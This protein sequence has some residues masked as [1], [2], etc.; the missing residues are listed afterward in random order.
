MTTDYKTLLNAAQYDAVVYND[1]P[2]LIVAG[3]GSGKTRVLTYKI[4]YLIE[5]GYPAA[6]ILA[7]TFTNK[8]ARE[9]KSRIAKVVGDS[10][11]RWLWM[12]TFHSIFARI[13]RQE[14]NK[15]S[16]SRDFT[17]YDAA[18]SKG[19][20]RD[21]IKELELDEKKY[22]PKMVVGRISMAKN[23]LVT[24]ETYASSRDWRE[25]DEMHGCP[26][27]HEVYSKYSERC[28]IANAMDFDDLLL[29]V[30]ELF[31]KHPDVL[32]HYQ[33]KF[34]YILVD[35]YQDTNY[36][37]H[38]IVSLLSALHN[39][40]CV[41]GDDAQSI[42]S[43][44][45][46]NIGNMLHFQSSF[47]G[48]RV[49]KLEQNYR[50]TQTIVNAANAL[51]E[52]N[53]NQIRK[54]VFSEL[55]VGQKIV[56]SRSISDLDEGD[57][58]AKKIERLVR[59]ERRKPWNEGGVEHPYS[60]IA[61]LYRTNAQSRA[62]EKTFVREGIPYKIFGGLS[63]YQRK[64]IK[65]VL[66]YMRLVINGDDEE[67][68][69]RIINYPARKI[70][71]VTQK[72][73]LDAAHQYNTSPL[74]I[75]QDI[76]GYHVD[77][78]GTTAKV[79][80]QFGAMIADFAE[81][82][83][84]TD[85]YALAEDIIHRSGIA[86]DILGDDDPDN[87]ERRQNIQELL[88]AI[89]EF[90]VERV[91]MG[92][93]EISLRDFL[94]EVALLTDQDEKE[95]DDVDRV[96]LMTIHS[97]KG[98]EFNHVFIV[99]V[100]EGLMPM[101]EDSNDQELEEER[102]LCYVAITRAKETCNISYAQSRFRNGVTDT[103]MPSRF[104]AEIGPE[105]LDL[106]DTYVPSFMAHPTYTPFTTSPRTAARPVTTAVRNRFSVNAP[107]QPSAAVSNL[108]AAR[109]DQIVVGAKVKHATFG[110][111]QVVTIEGNDVGSRKAKI[112]FETSGERVLLLKYAKL[113][114]IQ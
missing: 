107:Q 82:K 59:K 58:V 50:S 17:I 20:I 15:L 10:L 73:I 11:S 90:C 23:N 37:Q 69:K 35:E 105:F 30:N 91:N 76:F 27:L 74:N 67:A 89:N 93:N 40:I 55:P 44:R 8:A 61:V 113:E 51:I 54:N 41:V 102:R 72:K 101:C 98:L 96:T 77:L 28:R 52:H 18:D 60:Q 4:A 6:S 100:E 22:K 81:A 88:N 45:G 109:P 112:L 34:K 83:S 33:E 97:A 1:G 70:G 64:E 75:A 62:L 7:L 13:L 84:T 78:K 48:C 110:V 114:I 3:A 43:F 66:A 80:Q 106:P 12:G 32:R 103:T 92:D 68:F 56:V 94:S 25:Q 85:A 36:V 95:P 16:F 29:N 5:S 108:R 24:A 31:V 79:V 42:Y 111:G 99:G 57:S 47:K 87:K 39:R 19:M 26:R 9:M 46:A 38:R 53:R 65:D 104:I 71:A 21:I 63:F 2:S 86:A 49:F 14:A